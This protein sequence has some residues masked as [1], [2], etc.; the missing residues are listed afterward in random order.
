M[1]GSY[2]VHFRPQDPST[3]TAD[4]LASFG[5]QFNDDAE[6]QYVAEA[7]GEEAPPETMEEL[8]TYILVRYLVVQELSQCVA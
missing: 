8:Q 2:T 1:V 6:L 7:L 3:L 5:V 4:T